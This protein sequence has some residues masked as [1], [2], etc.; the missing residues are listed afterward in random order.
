[1]DALPIQEETDLPFASQTHGVMH[2][3]GHDGHTTMLLGSAVLL[4]REGRLPAAVR[5]IFQPAEETGNGADEM[6][7]AGVLDDVAM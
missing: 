2:A 3:C 5:L 1:M 7:K 4:A 6:I